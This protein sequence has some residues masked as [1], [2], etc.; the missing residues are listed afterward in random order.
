MLGKGWFNI[1]NAFVYTAL[2]LLMCF[3]AAGSMKKTT[4]L[5]FAAVN[6]MTWYLTPS[7]WEN[8]LWLTGS[9]FYA[10]PMT[11]IL[12]FLVPLRKKCGNPD[13]ALNVPLS[14]CYSVLGLLAGLTYEN[15]AAGVF[16]ALIGYFAVKA[17]KKEK[18]ALFEIT[19]AVGFLIG[20]VV[21][22]A[23]PGNFSRLESYEAFVQ[24][25]FFGYVLGRL[26]VTTHI[27]FSR[28]GALLTGLSAMLFLEL[29]LHQKKKVPTFSLVYVIL[30][31]ASAYSMV[32]APVFLERAFFPAT[33]FLIVGFM[34]LFLQVEWPQML[35]RHLKIFVV[36]ML[37]VFSSSLFREGVSMMKVYNGDIDHAQTG[38]Q[39]GRVQ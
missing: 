13:Y 3:H 4:C 26:F 19:G 1:A 36:L 10:W 37:L 11:I 18:A 17:R 32:M 20:F 30:G 5:V 35:K 34:N 24:H 21:L 9:S 28:N 22:I 29:W 23:A 15:A 2:M 16:V 12:A 14:V 25:G 39:F 6:L 31:V 8:F 7:W 38:K 33:T 27:F